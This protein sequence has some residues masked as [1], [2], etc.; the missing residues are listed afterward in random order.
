MV[1][2]T[3][4]LFDP[5]RPMPAMVG[6]GNGEQQHARC[7]EYRQAH[8]VAQDIRTKD[9]DQAADARERRRNHVEQTAETGPGNHMNS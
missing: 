9:Q 6:S 2:S 7:G 8:L 5:L 4:P 1:E 3:Q